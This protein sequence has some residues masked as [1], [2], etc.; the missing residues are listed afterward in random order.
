MRRALA[1]MISIRDALSFLQAQDAVMPTVRKIFDRMS[2]LRTM[3]SDVSLPP[4][5][6]DTWIKSI[7]GLLVPVSGSNRNQPSYQILN[8]YFPGSDRDVSTSKQ[9]KPIIKE[10]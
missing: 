3:T 5:G 2:Q 8:H 6:H 10:D 9:I 4:Q 7:F 1:T